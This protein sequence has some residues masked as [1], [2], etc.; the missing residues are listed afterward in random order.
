V[1]DDH[2]V[3]NLF[4]ADERV[5]VEQATSV[6]HAPRR[7]RDLLQRKTRSYTGL[8][9]ARDRG[10]SKEGATGSS[11]DWLAVVR[12]DPRRIIDLPVY[13]GVSSIA[14]LRAR[15]RVARGRTQEW[16]TDQSTRGSSA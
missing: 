5:V 10:Q 2:F 9:E 3:H 12:T 4:S 16:S 14:K 6:V 7:L 15:R 1:A 11:L 13:L 8:M